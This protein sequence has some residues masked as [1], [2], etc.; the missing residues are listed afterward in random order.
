MH[1]C[2]VLFMVIKDPIKVIL[3]NFSFKSVLAYHYTL[4]IYFIL[5]FHTPAFIP[6]MVLSSY[7]N[8]LEKYTFST[9]TNTIHICTYSNFIRLIPTIIGILKI[10]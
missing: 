10:I 4:H 8:T 3:F 5:V 7:K 9:S 1:P 2:N 6:F